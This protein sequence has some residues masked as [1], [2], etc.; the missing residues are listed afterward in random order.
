MPSAVDP[1]VTNIARLL[2]G[3]S[4]ANP[5]I[6]PLIEEGKTYITH[7]RFITEKTSKQQHLSVMDLSI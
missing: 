5:S 6:D 1:K 2:E 4:E 3:A 7:Q